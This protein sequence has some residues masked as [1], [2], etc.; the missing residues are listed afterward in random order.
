[1]A[2]VVEYREKPNIVAR[3]FCG[4][5]N[6]EIENFTYKAVR[7]KRYKYCPYCGEEIDWEK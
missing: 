2:K 4:K 6:E 5:C 1:M 7:I 3:Y